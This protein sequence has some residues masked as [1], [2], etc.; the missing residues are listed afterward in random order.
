MPNGSRSVQIDG[1]LRGIEARLNQLDS[2]LDRVIDG[3]TEADCSTRQILT[4]LSDKID[5]VAAKVDEHPVG[6]DWYTPS[7]VAKLM[8]I[9]VH[10]VRVRW[11]KAGRIDCEKVDGRWMIPREEFERLRLGGR[12]R[13]V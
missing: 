4:E 6:K 8:N 3:Q 7:D 10:T 11:C 2:K 1:I 12:P 9:S 5:G 13:G